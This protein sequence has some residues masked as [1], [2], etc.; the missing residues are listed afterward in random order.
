MFKDA[1]VFPKKVAPASQQP[2]MIPSPNYV[3]QPQPVKPV[4]PTQAPAY[5][6]P[7]VAKLKFFFLK[8][9]SILIGGAAILLIVWR[10]FLK[11]L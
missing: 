5:E 6:D 4:A 3:A 7:D 11:F 8:W 1:F 10:I 2:K 9:L